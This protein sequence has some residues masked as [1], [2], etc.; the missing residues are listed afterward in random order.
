MLEKIIGVMM[1]LIIPMIL[2]AGAFLGSAID[3]NSVLAF[4]IGSTF[5]VLSA[6]N[7]AFVLICSYLESQMEN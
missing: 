5:I 2:F 7:F 3:H 1:L 6:F 4:I